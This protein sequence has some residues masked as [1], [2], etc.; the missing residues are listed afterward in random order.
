[1]LDGIEEKNR[2]KTLT[3]ANVHYGGAAVSRQMY[4]AIAACTPLAS[5]AAAPLEQLQKEFGRDCF[6]RGFTKLYS[7]ARMC[8]KV[9]VACKVTA[10]SLFHHAVSGL[11][12]ELRYQLLKVDDME[13]PKLQCTRGRSSGKFGVLVEVYIDGRGIHRSQTSRGRFIRSIAARSR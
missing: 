13:V 12:F 11:L 5:H 3:S 6:T 2:H 7:L 10:E 4:Y 1:M 8:Q 9:A